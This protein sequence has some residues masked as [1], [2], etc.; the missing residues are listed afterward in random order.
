MVLDEARALFDRLDDA[1]KGRINRTI[2]QKVV[3]L[4]Q[5]IFVDTYCEL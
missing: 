4:D 1:Q 2:M 3:L 5:L